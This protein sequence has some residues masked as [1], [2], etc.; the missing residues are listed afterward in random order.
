MNINYEIRETDQYG[1]GMFVLTDIAAGTCI[2]SYKLNENVFEYD[3]AQSIAYLA[4][5]PTLQAQ[6][7]FLDA[8]FGKGPVLCLINDDGQ[9]INH[10]DASACN[11][12]TDL[13]SGDC[14]SIRAIAAGEQIFEDYS[15]FSHPAFLFPLLKQYQCEPDYYELPDRE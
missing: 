6:Q 9:Y 15:S 8:S 3:E 10:A 7:R 11:C 1:K 14:Y 2:W 5:L 13:S 12:R 4:A